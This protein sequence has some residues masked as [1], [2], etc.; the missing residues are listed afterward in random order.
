MSKTEH[1]KLLQKEVTFLLPIQG[2][3][4]LQIPY[5]LGRE[6]IQPKSKLGKKLRREQYKCVHDTGKKF[7]DVVK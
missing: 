5:F 1:K 7:N 2:Y 6:T 4:F 3:I